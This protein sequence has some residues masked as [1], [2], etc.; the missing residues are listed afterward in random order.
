[1]LAMVD[2][3]ATVTQVAIGNCEKGGCRKR[4]FA[5]VD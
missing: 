4:G 3:W 5:I 1:M 2:I